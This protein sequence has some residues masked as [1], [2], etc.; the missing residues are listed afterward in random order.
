MCYMKDCPFESSSFEWSCLGRPV[1]PTAE[2]LLQRD[3]RLGG[4]GGR[5]HHALCPQHWAAQR[6]V[7]ACVGFAGH[8]AVVPPP[9]PPWLSL[10][11][12]WQSQHQIHVCPFTSGV[13]V[14][15]VILTGD[16]L[17]PHPSPR[18]PGFIIHSL[19]PCIGHISTHIFLRKRVGTR[20]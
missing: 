1:I 13:T 9:F 18:Q 3:A 16:P 19:T 7:L 14:C 20:T 11:P 10:S 15:G 17:L 6:T 4:A 8:S 5:A 2:G 12:S